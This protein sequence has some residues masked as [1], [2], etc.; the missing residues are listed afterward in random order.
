MSQSMIDGTCEAILRNTLIK[1]PMCEIH[2]FCISFGQ[3]YESYDLPIT[4]RSLYTSSLLFRIS[5]SM[6]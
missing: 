6:V 4:K 5:G 1:R 2:F 3:A